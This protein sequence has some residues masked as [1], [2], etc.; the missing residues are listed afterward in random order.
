[1]KRLFLSIML[2]IAFIA[3]LPASIFRPEFALV[4][5]GGGARG[6]AHI[7]VLE[8]LDR[9]GIV[10]DIIIGTSMGA[11]VGSLYA[12]GYSGEE[13]NQIVRDT[14]LMSYFIHLYAVRKADVLPSPFTDYDTNLLTVEFGSSGFGA[15]NGLIDDQYING[16][17]RRY[18]SKVL[19]IS[20]FD[21]LPIP[22]RAI[23]TDITNNRMS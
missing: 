7:P 14:D 20:D 19:S 3:V 15:S 10:P 17:L 8:E 2:F 5:S 6:I 22:F 4:L 11:V 18:L 23:G 21:D 12:A 9:R 1:M 16:F 13:L